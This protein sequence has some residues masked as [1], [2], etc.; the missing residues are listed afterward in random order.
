VYEAEVATGADVAPWLS[1]LIPVYNVQNYLEECVESV[2]CQGG[3]AVEVILLDDCST[4]G[5]FA[6]MKSLAQR[7][8]GRL[9]LMQHATN[10]GLS[11]ARNTM[12]DAAH[13]EYLWFLDSDDKLMPEA[14]KELRDIVVTHAPDVVLCDFKT[15]RDEGVAVGKSTEHESHKHT[16]SGPQYQL[17]HERASVMAGMLL[18]GLLHAWSKVSR[19]SLWTSH[20]RFPEGKYFEDMLPIL[21]MAAEADSFFYQPCPWVAYRQR[22]SSIMNSMNLTKIHDYSAALVPLRSAF[23]GKAWAEDAELR[24]MWAHQCARNFMAGV[25]YLARKSGL[26]S[27]EA[28]LIAANF[29]ADFEA[30]S[31]LSAS[32]LRRE[33]LRRGWFGRCLKFH[34]WFRY[35][36]K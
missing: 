21:L 15:F 31:P 17:M 28:S 12:I 30:A 32:Q 34:R 19:R 7:W 25:R 13:G 33:Y 24:F 1:I 2:M 5:S 16:F 14:V 9:T 6:L 22:E 26:P 11:A 4:D 23:S 18:V 3:G 20:V 35:S 36:Q 8:P 29:R 27:Q 10:R